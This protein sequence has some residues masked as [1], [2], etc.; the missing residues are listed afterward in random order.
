M[1]E[2]ANDISIRIAAAVSATLQE[3]PLPPSF[4]H[5][6]HH[7]T[8]LLW[9]EWCLISEKKNSK[10]DQIKWVDCRRGCNGEGDGEGVG[11]AIIFFCVR[12]EE[13]TGVMEIIIM[14]NCAVF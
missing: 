12:G 13:V 11:I 3:F 7:T 4:Y 10:S 8:E 14:L 6:R 9:W 2:M 1:S 5:H